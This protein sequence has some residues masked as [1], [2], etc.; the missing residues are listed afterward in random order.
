MHILLF[1]PSAKYTALHSA[2]LERG[3]ACHYANSREEAERLCMDRVPELM[4][5]TSDFQK[6]SSLPLLKESRAAFGNC[7]TFVVTANTDAR[8]IVGFIKMGIRST[9]PGNLEIPELAGRI[10]AKIET[11]G[12][13]PAQPTPLRTRLSPQSSP[14]GESFRKGSLVLN[15]KPLPSPAMP[16]AGRAEEDLTAREKAIAERERKL[17]RLQKEI[18]EREAYLE[19]C[20]NYLMEKTQDLT[21]REAEIQQ[22]EAAHEGTSK[23]A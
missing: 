12:A 22:L 2:L 10:R 7:R 20:E 23:S 16:P 13:L 8:F 14:L 9:F 6:E 19:E 1:D 15:A 4:I 5:F 21:V 17:A 11:M 3:V 18:E